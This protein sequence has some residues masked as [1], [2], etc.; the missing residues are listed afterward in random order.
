MKILQLP[1]NSFLYF[2]TFLTIF[3][4]CIDGFLTG[5]FLKHNLCYEFNPLMREALAHGELFLFIKFGL[6]PLFCLSLLFAYQYRLAR[7]ALYLVSF[8]Y[9]SLM[10]VWLHML[11]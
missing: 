6:V 9:T 4:N 8:L 1:K 10:V 11:M 2:L 5:M 3:C 7:Y